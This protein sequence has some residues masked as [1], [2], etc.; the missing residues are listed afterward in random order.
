[1][2]TATHLPEITSTFY[3]P[4][5][6]LAVTLALAL[7]LLAAAVNSRA[8]VLTWTNTVSDYWAD[9]QA[10]GTGI[11]PGPADDA[12]FS[13]TTTF[14]VTITNNTF[15]D[16]IDVKNTVGQILTLD[17]QGNTIAL[18]KPGTGQPTVFLSGD[19][20]GSTAIVYIVSST[21][22]GT[23]ICT[24]AGTSSSNGIRFS[25]GR[26]GNG[27]IV[28]S[29]MTVITGGGLFGNN[30]VICG[31]STGPGSQGHIIIT[32]PTTYWTNNASL[33]IGNNGAA[34]SNLVVI[35]DSASMTCV[36]TFTTGTSGASGNSLLVDSGGQFYTRD[37]KSVV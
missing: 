3:Q 4:F 12:T 17:T 30:Q 26:S 29:N 37:R 9:P 20:S 7:G 36:G 31:N 10:W 34:T 11:V 15:L 6:R 13:A 24:N 25:A 2:R 14:T 1:M 35:S 16:S 27:T 8:A 5:H 21:T 28:V 33:N 32:G 19:S 23:M 22:P 18:Y